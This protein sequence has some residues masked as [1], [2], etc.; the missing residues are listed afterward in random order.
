M[1]RI[2]AIETSCDE[3][4]AAV[5]EDGRHIL[6]N[7]V[8]SQVELH[9]QYG[10]VFPEIASSRSRLERGVPAYP[11]IVV[12]RLA[13]VRVEVRASIA[14]GIIRVGAVGV[15][16]TAIRLRPPPVVQIASKRI[17]LAAVPEGSL[18][19]RSNGVW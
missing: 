2:L 19:R 16:F 9:A 18:R 14:D 11:R 7:V 10:G 15:G 17:L 12:I 3:T 1:T 5:V 13:V 8:T 6:S 4:A